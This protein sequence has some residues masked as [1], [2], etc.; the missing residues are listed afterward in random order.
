VLRRGLLSIAVLSAIALVPTDALG[1]A[2]TESYRSA[3]AQIDSGVVV[4]GVIN[5]APR[6]VEVLLRSHA[7]Y[8]AV[9]PPGGEPALLGTLHAHHV[10]VEFARRAHA[11]AKA[12]P[13]H[14][15]LRYIAA[16]ILGALLVIA[17]GV[18]FARRR[19]RAAATG[20]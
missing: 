13:V 10:K 12:Q 19:R 4:R 7:E 6:H 18:L 1:V 5:A 2:P 11:R 20:A 15:H 17:G 8:L 9:Y 16:G 3:L 14:H